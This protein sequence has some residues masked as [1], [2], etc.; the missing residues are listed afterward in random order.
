MRHLPA[1]LLALATAPALAQPAYDRDAIGR[2]AEREKCRP[3]PGVLRSG[4]PPVRG[5]DMKYAR[6]HWTLDP[7]V[8][9]ISG[10]VTSWFTATAPLDAVV[11]DLSDSL[12]VTAVQMHGAPVAF[13]HGPGDLLT[14]NLPATLPAGQ[15]D[16]LTVTYQGQ[17][18]TTGFGSFATESHAGVPV[19]WTLSEPYGSKDWWPCKDDLN[20]KIDSMDTYVTVPLGNR[21]AGNGLLM[22]GD[23][24]GNQVTWHWR[25]RYPIDPYLVGV[26]VTNYQVNEQYAPIATGDLLVLTYAYPENY[27]DAVNGATG[28][29][30]T[31]TLYDQL[32]GDYPFARE[33]YG[34]AQFNWGG[35]MEHQTMSFVGG[36]WPEVLNHELAH[37][38]FGDKVTCGSWAELWLN[39][40]FATYLS[41]LAYEHLAPVY[42]PIWK[43]GLVNNITSQPGGSVFCTDTLDQ[44]RLFSGRLT[45]NKG[46]MVI[47]MLRWLCGDSAFYAGLRNYLDDPALAY[48]TATTADLQGHLEAA[49]GLDLTGFFADWY[50]GEGYPSYTTVWSQDA[51]GAV[52]VNLSQVTSHPSVS[53]FA[54][55]VPLKFFGPGGQDTTVVL[56]N[57][58]NGQSFNFHLSF[59]VDS[60][61]FDPETWLISAQDVVT[62]VGGPGTGPVVLLHPN[63]ATDRINWHFSAPVQQHSVRVLDALGR[64][65]LHNSAG[66]QSLD[67]SK[68]A[69][70]QYVLEVQG[71]QGLMRA[72]FVKQ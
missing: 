38:W 46:A 58:I 28:L 25:H 39:E 41:G 56:N 13:S 50:T 16:S 72:R 36:Y 18:P 14:I 51:A 59:T 30:P 67:V 31:I 55:P 60:V 35:G 4:G 54:L 7:A 63:P 17:P 52:A 8:R 5:F 61:Q 6:C 53:F 47:H 43:R 26:A 29:L 1:L 40:G 42:W 64:P 69:P 22:G 27:N 71:K 34:H 11:L 2:I 65:V 62:Q 12:L 44:N 10:S 21:A 37:Q 57:T 66:A 49:S 3:F 23:T 19:L 9:H 70:G 32:F 68:L 15:L 45:Y 20:D 24:T 48:R 33:K